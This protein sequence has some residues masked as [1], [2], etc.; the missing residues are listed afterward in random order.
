MSCYRDG[1][2]CLHTIHASIKG[3]HMLLDTRSAFPT[4]KGLKIITVVRG[5]LEE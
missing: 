1:V 5:G 2:Y 3:S 4:S